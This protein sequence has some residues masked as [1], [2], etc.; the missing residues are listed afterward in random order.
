MILKW[1]VKTLSKKNKLIAA[2]NFIYI[3]IILIL[4]VLETTPAFL[5]LGGVKPKLVMAFCIVV[6]IFEAEFTGGLL[7]ALGGILY[8]FIS[9]T[10]VGFFSIQ[11]LVICTATGLAFI[12]LIKNTK[13]SALVVTA[14]VLT[15][16]ALSEF[17]FFYGM[18]G[19]PGGIK[20]LTNS[21]LPQV[22]YTLP[23]ALGFYFAVEYIHRYFG[24]KLDEQF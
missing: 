19:T 15:F 16:F 14:G 21:L 18:W 13:A 4:F 22:L 24:E 7:G 12:Y 5:R 10:F 23:F 3:L 11:M 2:K 6:A 1:E 20:V 17:Y 8:D 9:Y